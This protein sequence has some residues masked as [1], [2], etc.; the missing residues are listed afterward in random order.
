MLSLHAVSDAEDEL[1]TTS[2]LPPV[3]PAGVS[4]IFTAFSEGITVQPE[5]TSAALPAD[6]AACVNQLF[7]SNLA[8]MDSVKALKEAKRP[9][10]VDLKVHRTH[11]EVYALRH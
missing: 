7:H 9:A 8:G 4:S 5:D 11:K 2:V 10:N 3:D 6:M 1:S